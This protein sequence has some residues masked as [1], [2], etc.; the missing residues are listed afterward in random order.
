MLHNNYNTLI[1]INI[2]DDESVIYLI[3]N[4][5][6]GIVYSHTEI[7][8]NT[9]IYQIGFCEYEQMCIFIYVKYSLILQECIFKQ[10]DSCN[11]IFA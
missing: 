11:D 10:E 8:A 7:Y 3:Y 6:L 4:N 9:H 2:W 5:V 1:D